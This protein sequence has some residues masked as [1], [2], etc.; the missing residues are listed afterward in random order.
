MDN[1]TEKPKPTFPASIVIFLVVLAVIFLGVVGVG[2]Y[3]FYHYATPDLA[4][5]IQQV[6]DDK[7]NANAETAG[8]QPQ[9]ATGATPTAIGFNNQG[10]EYYDKN[11]YANAEAYFRKAIATDP[12]LANPYNNLGIVLELTGKPEEAAVNFRKAIDIYPS[13]ANAYSNL[14]MYYKEKKN[15]P[16]AIVNFK[17]AI[18]IDGNLY[19]PYVNL[20]DVYMLL[21]DYSSAKIFYEKALKSTQ[22]DPETVDA[23]QKQLTFINRVL[24]K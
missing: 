18:N 2:V 24:S 16:Q 6:A 11:D 10:L 4:Q 23:V 22:I 3:M 12:Y 1:F 15:Y 8:A 14:G 5:M 17:K 13:Y 21:N 20:G 9:D 19:K 7:T